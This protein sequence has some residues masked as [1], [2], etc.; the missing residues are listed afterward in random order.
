MRLIRQDIYN[1]LY[2]NNEQMLEDSMFIKQ[3]DSLFATI[4][5]LQR[6]SNAIS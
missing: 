4:L 2:S 5:I 1:I 6:I 3:Y